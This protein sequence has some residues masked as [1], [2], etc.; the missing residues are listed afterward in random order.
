MEAPQQTKRE[1]ARGFSLRAISFKS[2]KPILEEDEDHGEDAFSYSL[3]DVVKSNS[4][5]TVLVSSTISSSSSSAATLGVA[6]QEVSDKNGKNE[7][8]EENQQQKH[9]EEV[10]GDD[11]NDGDDDVGDDND[12][13]TNESNWQHTL[14]NNPMITMFKDLAKISDTYNDALA[15]VA[16]KDSL[17]HGMFENPLAKENMAAAS[18][19]SG[20]SSRSKKKPSTIK[21]PEA[22]PIASRLS[23]KFATLLTPS[24][25]RKSAKQL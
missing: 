25:K 21:Q 19:Q 10:N 22:S 5:D 23:L 7:N 11:D 16:G 20:S 4:K 3:H 2:K 14:E 13:E 15:N 9:E 12:S 6:Q 1:S 17:S 18:T 24:P 8:E